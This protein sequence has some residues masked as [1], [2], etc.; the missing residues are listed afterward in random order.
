[1][2]NA[3]GFGTGILV[4]GLMVTPEKRKRE[5]CAINRIERPM[6]K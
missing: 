6:D 4:D 2:Q 1:V 3:A 5:T